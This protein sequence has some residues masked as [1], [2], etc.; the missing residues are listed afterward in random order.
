MEVQYLLIRD[1]S[2]APGRPSNQSSLLFLSQQS[3][4]TLTGPR[5]FHSSQNPM[6]R[7]IP[8]FFCILGFEGLHVHHPGRNTCLLKPTFHLP[9][10]RP[11]SSKTNCGGWA[12]KDTM[13]HIFSF[14]GIQLIFQISVGTPLPTQRIKSI[15]NVSLSSITHLHI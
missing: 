13:G 4:Y 12:I 15:F 3:S 5:I 1:A 2:D 7:N 11:N 8:C 9:L 10:L 6:I 14:L